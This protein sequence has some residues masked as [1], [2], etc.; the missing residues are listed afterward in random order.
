MDWLERTREWLRALTS[1]R[2]KVPSGFS[3]ISPASGAELTTLTPEEALR[4]IPTLAKIHNLLATAANRLNFYV[5]LLGNVLDEE[6]YHFDY[7]A[8]SAFA[9]WYVV[10]YAVF[11]RNMRYIPISTIP[12]VATLGDDVV[13]VTNVR[14]PI[15]TAQPILIAAWEYY[16]ALVQA[17]KNMGAWNFAVVSTEAIRTKTDVEEIRRMFADKRR[18]AGV[19]GIEFLAL[20]LEFKSVS[21][22][23]PN[24]A[25][26]KLATL[27]NREI[28]DLY[29]IDSALLNDPENKTYANKSE[30]LKALYTHVILPACDQFVEATTRAFAREGFSYTFHY[31]TGAME[32]LLEDKR[33]TAAIL[34]QAYSMGLV[35]ESEIRAFFRDMLG[36]YAEREEADSQISA[37]GAR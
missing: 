33:A 16:R 15:Q 29:A 5:R 28:C 17:M 32:G 21:P 30:A 24:L 22:E 35:K 1:V 3:G 31:A 36:R 18:K 9:D 19:G 6:S 25:L 13:V 20:P 11:D 7:Y 27:I 23:M 8:G 10:G 12:D 4:S 2:R 34:M 14:R 37:L 26:D